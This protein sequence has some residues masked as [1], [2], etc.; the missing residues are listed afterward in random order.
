MA[1]KLY[2]IVYRY[3][4]VEIRKHETYSKEQHESQLAFLK[5]SKCHEIIEVKCGKGK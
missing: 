5:K 4:G 2:T 1:A 3:M